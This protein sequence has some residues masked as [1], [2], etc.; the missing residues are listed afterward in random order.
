MRQGTV[1]RRVRDLW[2]ATKTECT[3]HGEAVVRPSQGDGDQNCPYRLCDERG[4]EV[5]QVWQTCENEQC[6]PCELMNKLDKPTLVGLGLKRNERLAAH[7]EIATSITNCLNFGDLPNERKAELVDAFCDLLGCGKTKVRFVANVG[8]LCMVCPNLKHLQLERGW[9][10]VWANL[11][12][13]GSAIGYHTSPQSQLAALVFLV[14]RCVRGAD[15]KW[16]WYLQLGDREEEQRI[17]RE[18]FAG[19]YDETG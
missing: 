3:C 16:P 15:N 11:S 12:K 2:T 18:D 4:G 6:T 17:L 5:D 10:D 14:R 13:I 19:C 8:F 9:G 1:S 7:L